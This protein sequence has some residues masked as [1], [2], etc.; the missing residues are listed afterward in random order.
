MKIT[1]AGASPF[2][3][4]LFVTLSCR[5]QSD[6]RAVLYKAHRNANI[7]YRVQGGLILLILGERVYYQCVLSFF[8]RNVCRLPL[9]ALLVYSPIGGL[10]LHFYIF[11]AHTNAHTQRGE[12]ERGQND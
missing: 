4:V 5:V 1:S 8:V 12:R 11:K 6:S 7:K 2:A 9:L 10:G 3:G